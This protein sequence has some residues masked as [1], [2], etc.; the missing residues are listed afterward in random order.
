MEPRAEDL[1]AGKPAGAGGAGGAGDA[2][3]RGL[4]RH[5]AAPRPLS[6]PRG[7]LLPS[8]LCPGDRTPPPHEG[9][10]PPSAVPAPCAADFLML[11]HRL[12]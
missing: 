9:C 2:P 6:A 1:M 12:L 7:A 11:E 4:L 8:M 3:W 5:Q 10:V